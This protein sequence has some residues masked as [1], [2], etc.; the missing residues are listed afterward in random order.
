MGDIYGER[1]HGYPPYRNHNNNPLPPPSIRINNRPLIN[2]DVRGYNGYTGY[3]VS[4]VYIFWTVC[5]DVQRFCFEF[6]KGRSIWD[7]ESVELKILQ[8]SLPAFLFFAAP[9]PVFLGPPGFSLTDTLFHFLSPPHAVL[10]SPEE[11]SRGLRI[12]CWLIFFHYLSLASLNIWVWYKRG[13]SFLGE[14]RL[15]QPINLIKGNLFNKVI[16]VEMTVLRESV[17]S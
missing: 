15:N 13:V 11:L 5:N 3:Q 1:F 9:L 14:F 8:T 7:P 12:L 4:I 17:P 2:G 6:S 16:Y 10:H